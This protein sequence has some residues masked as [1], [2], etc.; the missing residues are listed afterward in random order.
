MT[1]V[2][3]FFDDLWHFVGLVVVIGVTLDGVASVTRGWRGR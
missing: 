3:F 2:Q 1:I